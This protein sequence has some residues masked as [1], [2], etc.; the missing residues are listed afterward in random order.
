MGVAH[1]LL[2]DGHTSI[3]QSA[4]SS[5]HMMLTPSKGKFH[6]LVLNFGR[7]GTVMDMILY[8]F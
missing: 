6:L 8:G 3:S 1:C 2:K 4:Y 5:D 7:P